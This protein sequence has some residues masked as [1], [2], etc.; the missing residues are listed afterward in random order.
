MKEGRETALTN[1][2]DKQKKRLKVTLLLVALTN[3]V[4]V[5]LSPA[6]EQIRQ[7]FGVEL[8]T[9]QTAMSATNIIQIAVSLMAM[10]LINRGFLT[11]KLAVVLGQSFFGLAVLFVLLFHNAFW[12]VYVLSAL[13]GGACGLFVTNAFGIIFDC[14]EPD[15]RQGLTGLQTSCISLG[16]ILASLAGGF[17]AGFFWYGGYLVLSVGIV[18]AVIAAL[19]IPSY[20]TPK[21][22]NGVKRSPIR[23]QVF[24]YAASAFLFM[25]CY[26]TVGQNISSH[27]SR[28]F[29]D[30]SRLAGICSAVQMGGG[31]VSGLLFKKISGRLQDD[32]LVL[33]LC[34]LSG[35]LLLLS[36]LTTSLPLILL[37]VFLCGLTLSLFN[38]WCIFG[39][40]VNSDPTNS[41]VTSVIISAIAPSAGGFLSPVVFTNVTNALVPGATDFRY[42]FVAG[43]ALV[44]AALIFLRNRLVKKTAKG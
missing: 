4:S 11:K 8:A 22:E 15:E 37:S 23:R 27:L 31:V 5:A 26:I 18:I 19:N 42:R 13:V 6:T 9:V 43:C 21:A 17:L 14:F 24:F 7:Y 25:L 28:H 35:G 39:V 10:Y 38:P 12:C 16:G 20:K 1:L 32:T 44:I 29:A 2:S 34:V 41:A 40:S 33:A 36:F 3:M 30:F